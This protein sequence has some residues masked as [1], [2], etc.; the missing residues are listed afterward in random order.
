V[1]IIKKDG[2]THD[3][4][5]V[6]SLDEIKETAKMA[7]RLPFTYRVMVLRSESG[8]GDWV[9]LADIP[10]A[11]FESLPNTVDDLD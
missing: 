8:Y 7:R 4:P 2:Q 11:A 10:N 6:G 3:L 9:I 1:R 5:L